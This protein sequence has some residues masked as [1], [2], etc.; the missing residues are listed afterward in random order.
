MS[1]EERRVVAKPTEVLEDV[2]LQ[3]NDLEKFTR[4]GTSMK[5]K[6]RKDIIQFLRKSIDVFAWSH[7]DMP[8]IDPSVITHRLNVYPFSKPVR[9][10]KRVFAPK[11]DKAI[12]EEVQKLTT[13]QFI[14]EVY[15]P[16]WLANVVMVKKANG[17]W[18]MYVDFTD[19]NKACPKDS[20][21]FPRIDQLVDSTAGHQLLSFMDAFSGYNQIKMD[22]VDQEKTSFITSQGLFCYKVMPFGLKNAGATYQRLVNH[23]FHPQI[24]RNVEVYVNEMLVKS[25]DEGSHL[26]DLQETFETLRLYK[27]K[28]N[29]SKYAFRV[30]SGKFLGFMVS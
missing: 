22:E 30:S 14:K 21:P 6:A 1:I 20:Y 29:P 16:D 19:L 24:G 10:K 2:L 18:R 27:M 26:D 25:L 12:K 23:M 13:T 4:I 28:L 3:E 17:R 15:Y 9:Q 7:D 5:E 11:R 8:G